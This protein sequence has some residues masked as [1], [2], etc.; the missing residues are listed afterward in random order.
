LRVRTLLLVLLAVVPALLLMAWSARQQRLAAAEQ[1]RTN[2]LRVARLAASDAQGKISA[3]RQFLTALARLPMIRDHDSAK[4]DAVFSRL[5]GQFPI[6]ANIGAADVNGVVFGSGV[7]LSAPVNISDRGYFKKALEGKRFAVGD[8]QVGRITGT[9]T[10]NFACPAFDSSGQVVAIAYAALRLDWVSRLSAWQLP[11][12]ATLTIVDDAGTILL[13]YPESDQWIGRSVPDSLLARSI[14]RTPEAT[15][16]GESLDG[17]QRLIAFTP[18]AT[19]AQRKVYVVVGVPIEAVYGDV[20]EIFMRNMAGMG[21]V[22]ILAL[23][24]AWLGGDWFFL[25]Q[26]KA[27]IHASRRISAGDLSARTGSR[28]GRDELSQLTQAFD[29]MADSLE[30]LTG[31]QEL[32]LSSAGEG[33][34]GVDTN[35]VIGFA[36]PAAARMLGYTQEEMI[37]SS[38]HALLGHSLRDGTP[39]LPDRCPIC[40][41]YREG[42][43]HRSDDEIFHRKDGTPIPVDYVATPAREHGRVIGA[44]IV[45]KDITARK[46]YEEE[47]GKAHQQVLESAIEKKQF[48][49]EVIRS[50]T[51]DKLH[52]LDRSDIREEGRLLL[53]GDLNTPQDD[54]AAR[55]EI[56]DI[57]KAAGMSLDDAQQ[58]VLAVGEASTNSVK[59]ATQGRYAVY[60]TDDRIIVRVSDKGP[61]ISPENLPATLLQAGFSTKVSLGMGYTLMLELVDRVFLTTDPEGTTIQLEKYIQPDKRPASPL[62]LAMQRFA[63][64]EPVIQ[65]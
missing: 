15:V 57:T 14:R 42:A 4:A 38:S 37:G 25:R 18:L 60:E 47:V 1:T 59:H 50:V 28:Y 20:D 55:H 8:Y 63:T 19:G 51:H 33:I 34:C 36:N 61:G 17:T 24:A 2:T 30:E 45:F 23:L 32:I 10:I 5:L 35:G 58:L 48:Y 53:E 16:E 6:Y 43:A 13:R 44:V 11:D 49:R 65:G 7:P 27:L 31:R 41:A 3:A 21:F 62:A 40:A 29:E 12:G 26:V 46:Q 9:P 64:K 22:A 52:L 54:R 39:H 56:R